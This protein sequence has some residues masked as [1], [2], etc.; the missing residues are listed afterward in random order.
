MRWQ[1]R[2]AQTFPHICNLLD[3]ETESL[4]RGHESRT[5]S[6][7]ARPCGAWSLR[8]EWSAMYREACLGRRQDAKARRPHILRSGVLP[9]EI[10]LQV[11]RAIL[12]RHSQCHAARLGTIYLAKYLCQQDASVTEHSKLSLG[13][14]CR[15]ANHS[16]TNTPR[17]P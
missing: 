4:E 16:K 10:Y 8:C 17:H 3:R 6:P 1:M 7:F 9:H 14:M 12:T 2:P 15:Q 13:E 11:M 5:P